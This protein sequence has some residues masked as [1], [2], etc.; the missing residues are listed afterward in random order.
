[1]PAP[2]GLVTWT[3]S[4]GA[5]TLVTT[6]DEYL[7]GAVDGWTW[8]VDLVTEAARGLPPHP[9]AVV[10]AAAA[11]VEELRP[12]VRGRVREQLCRAIHRILRCLCR[13]KSTKISFSF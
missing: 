3:P 7:P 6:I 4:D 11:L 5:A 8:A 12:R 13:Q 1:M 9:A 2:W 10:E